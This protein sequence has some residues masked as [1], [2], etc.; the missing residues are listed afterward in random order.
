MKHIPWIIRIGSKYLAHP[1]GGLTDDRSK[2][3]AYYYK[4]DAE[5]RLE[6]WCHM[7][8]YTMHV[9]AGVLYATPT[10]GLDLLLQ[11]LRKQG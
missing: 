10:K 5:N 9:T 11:V 1:R 8:G 4:K 7:M 3:Y 2:A 6:T